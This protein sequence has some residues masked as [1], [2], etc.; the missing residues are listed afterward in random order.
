MTLLLQ[1]AG[2]QT[3]SPV[4]LL[5][6]EADAGVTVSNVDKVDVWGDQS[7]NGYN[8]T[9]TGTARPALAIVGGYKC[10]Q[11]DGINDYLE[12]QNWAALDNMA[13]FTIFCVFTAPFADNAGSTP[14]LSMILTKGLDTNAGFSGL[15][16]NTIGGAAPWS[17]F[18]VYT[19][20][21]HNSNQAENGY[22][23]VGKVIVTHEMISFTKL[24]IY[25]NGVQDNTAGGTTAC[26]GYSSPEPLRIGADSFSEGVID[27]GLCG[28]LYAIRIYSPAINSAQRVMV[29]QELA[30]RYGITL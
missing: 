20:I 26:T 27:V 4:S 12:G 11:F 28:D 17:T 18:W 21:S 10:I 24:N 1:K 8:F 5:D 22:L 29:E 3:I 16:V 30:A 6:L 2:L 7:G 25:I 13:S 15:M 19:D 23:P 14:G 9:Q